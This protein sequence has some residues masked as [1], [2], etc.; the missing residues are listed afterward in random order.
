MVT[1]ANGCVDTTL[2]TITV[3]PSPEASFYADPTYQMIPDRTVN[4]V[5]TT[6]HGNWTYQWRFGDD[7]TSVLR[8]PGSHVYAGPDEYLI[9]LIVKGE[10]CA[11]S[12][13]TSVEI[14]PHPPVAAFKPV[15]GWIYLFFIN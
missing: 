13:W 5:N 10:H 11:D 7:S 14:V 15:H 12:A 4:L 1:N 8:D 3:H 2:K 9:Y 6:E